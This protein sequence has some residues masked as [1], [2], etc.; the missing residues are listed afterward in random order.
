MPLPPRPPFLASEKVCGEKKCSFIEIPHMGLAVAFGSGVPVQMALSSPVPRLGTR[1][2]LSALS[3]SF[4]FCSLA[5][6]IF[7]K[8]QTYYVSLVDW[9]ILPFNLMI[10]ES[11]FWW[12]ERRLSG[13]EDYVLLSRR[14]RV[15]FPA[16]AGSSHVSVT[17]ASGPFGAFGLHGHPHP[18]VCTYTWLKWNLFGKVILLKV[19]MVAFVNTSIC[20]VF[21]ACLHYDQAIR[22]HPDLEWIRA[23]ESGSYVSSSFIL[24]F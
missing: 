7:N 19:R 9:T 16:M 3:L 2:L 5:D 17:P 10:K 11:T 18:H 22:L 20:L 4:L 13:W 1:F 21:T 8:G 23:W 15:Q 6:T 12:L 24:A 14:T